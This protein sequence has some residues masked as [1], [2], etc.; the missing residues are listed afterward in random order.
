VSAQKAPRKGEALD[1]LIAAL[2]P[3]TLVVGKG[4]VGKTT[5]A[6]GLAA[7]A[8][9]AGAAL[10]VPLEDGETRAVT[11]APGLIARQLD[12]SRARREFLARWRETIVAIVDRGTY[13]D[14]EDIGGLVDA[15]FPGADE[16]FAVLALAELI[17]GWGDGRSPAAGGEVRRLVVDTAPTGH[18]LRLLAPTTFSTRCGGPWP[19]SRRRS[20]IRPARRCC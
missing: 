17:A 8:G 15:S 7:R 11:D 16:I 1:A 19:R 4:G 10:G 2:P 12:A 6:V 13:L 20:S 14:L 18:T 5:C 9:G 3:L